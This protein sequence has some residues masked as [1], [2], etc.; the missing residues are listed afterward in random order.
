M[1]RITIGNSCKVKSDWPVLSGKS[2]K[3]FIQLGAGECYTTEPCLDRAQDNSKPLQWTSTSV[4]PRQNYSAIIT[5]PLKTYLHF[6]QTESH[7]YSLSNVWLLIMMLSLYCLMDNVLL[8]VSCP[9]SNEFLA[10]FL[11]YLAQSSS[12]SP[13]SFEGFRQTLMQNFI[14]IQQ[15]LKNFPIDIHCKKNHRFRQ[16]QRGIFTMGGIK[17][18]IDQHV[19]NLTCYLNHVISLRIVTHLFIFCN[20]RLVL[21][22]NV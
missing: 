9:S 13:W 4:S 19:K 1:T 21:M 7:E 16:R 10:I 20:V 5:G 18:W 22:E 12:N 11:L 14:Q 17:K 2:R 8:S 3:S 15:W 6:L